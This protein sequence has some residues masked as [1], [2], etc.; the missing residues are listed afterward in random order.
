MRGLHIRF[1]LA[2]VIIFTVSSG[3]VFSAVAQTGFEITLDQNIDTPNR[4]IEFEGDA[5]RISAI[6]T[7]EQGTILTTTISGPSTQPY[8]I[9]IYN[10]N[11]EIVDSD[12]GNGNGAYEF[13]LD[14]YLP[15]SYMIA[16]MSDGSIKEVYP[17]VIKAY[18]LTLDAPESAQVGEGVEITVGAIKKSQ[19]KTLTDVQIALLN[20]SEE[21][22]EPATET[23]NG[24]YTGSISLNDLSPGTYRIYA[25]AHGPESAFGTKELI[26]IS[27]VGTIRVIEP[28]A[29]STSTVTGI[30]PV[31]S[32]QNPRSS[33]DNDPLSAEEDI[34]I[35]T[36]QPYR[37]GHPLYLF[38][39]SGTQN[40]RRFWGVFG[41]LA[42]SIVFVLLLK[43]GDSN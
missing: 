29:T 5:Y 30:S 19:G 26:G 6:G 3:M 31:V 11:R 28:S 15:G 13:S 34:T 18:E 2:V 1:I 32:P 12:T 37:R 8:R 4:I 40:E 38:G 22:R 10:K 27:D 20:D 39:F 36:K 23:S 21:I 25:T 14:E 24:V 35:R 16:L 7:Y 41:A 43:I 42:T 33:V 17:F 9:L